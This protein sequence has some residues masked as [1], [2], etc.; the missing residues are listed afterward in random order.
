MFYKSGMGKKIL[1]VTVAVLFLGNTIGYADNLRVPVDKTALKRAERLAKRAKATQSENLGSNT[2]VLVRILEDIDKAFTRLKSID[3]KPASKLIKEGLDS[4]LSSIM[5]RLNA[6]AADSSGKR[7]L[8]L[9]AR[10]NLLGQVSNVFTLMFDKLSPESEHAGKEAIAT[11]ALLEELSKDRDSLDKPFVFIIVHQAVTVNEIRELLSYLSKNEQVEEKTQDDIRNIKN[12]IRKNIKEGQPFIK[13]L[14]HELKE[15]SDY[16]VALGLKE[17]TD[18]IGSNNDV[19]RIIDVLK[20]LNSA[21]S[22][23]ALTIILGG[24]LAY[25]QNDLDGVKKDLNE[26]VHNLFEGKTNIANEIKKND[27]Y[28]MAREARFSDQKTFL[29]TAIFEGIETASVVDKGLGYIRATDYNVYSGDRNTYKGAVE[30]STYRDIKRIR[31]KWKIQE[32]SIIRKLRS[33]NKK[34]IRMLGSLTSLGSN[35]KNRKYYYNEYK[36]TIVMRQL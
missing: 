20:K 1:S 23:A 36:R 5:E 27:A 16:K 31:R 25:S 12:Y 22:I 7:E 24:E 32:W 6:L 3:K 19:Q 18:K 13:R 21:L 29:L 15:T 28:E 26:L 11:R 9:I 4:D 10:W 14:I 2:L 30:Y 35:Q 17:N 34:N 33:E 8:D